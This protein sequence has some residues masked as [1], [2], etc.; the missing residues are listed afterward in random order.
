MPFDDNGVPMDDQVADLLVK[1]ANDCSIKYSTIGLDAF[2]STKRPANQPKPN[3]RFLNNI[4]RGTNHHNRALQAKEN[5][6]SQAKLH[7]LEVAEAKK[8]NEEERKLRKAKPGPSDTRK[9]MLGDIAAILGGSPK[10]RRTEKAGRSITPT[11]NA[12]GTAK[13]GDGIKNSRRRHRSSTITDEMNAKKDNGHKDRKDRVGVPR[14][15]RHRE[16]SQY[17]SSSSSTTPKRR[18]RG[19]SSRQNSH[20]DSSV[21]KHSQHQSSPSADSSDSG[22]SEETIGPVPAKAPVVRRRGRGANATT[23]G[24][25]NRF[26]PDYDPR[27][28]ITPEA[29]DQRQEDD[30]WSHAVEAFRDRQKWNQRGEERLLSAGFTEEQVKKWKKGDQKDEADVQWATVG[31]LREWD[32]GKVVNKDGTVSFKNDSEW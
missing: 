25:D 6:E 4:I 16:E 19:R 28:D 23:S 1:E 3:T 27:K 31:G 18:R 12:S 2:K 9:R 11:S 30:E 20:R 32:R 22:S 13:S 24:I 5:A 7:D 10:K 26:A 14:Y 17:D 8:R 15:A 21:A 29:E